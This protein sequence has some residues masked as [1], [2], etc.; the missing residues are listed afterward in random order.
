[1]AKGRMLS[2]VV[3]TCVLAACGGPEVTLK[4]PQNGEV[5][6]CK[7]GVGATGVT[8][9]RVADDLMTKCV[10]GYTQ[11]GYEVVSAKQ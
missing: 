2:I 1:M 11:H 8:S 4:N 5:A 10:D 9:S 3:A 6:S 7:G